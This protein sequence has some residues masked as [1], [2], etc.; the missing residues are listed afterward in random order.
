M[1]ATCSVVTRDEADRRHE[2][3]TRRAAGIAGSPSRLGRFAVQRFNLVRY[4]AFDDMGGR[5]SFSAALLDDTVTD[6]DHL[7][8]RPDRGT[9]VKP[10]SELASEHNLSDEER[11][12]IA[13][14]LPVRAL[15]AVPC[16]RSLG[17]A[18]IDLKLLRD[19]PGAVRASLHARRGGVPQLD[20]V[21]ELDARYLTLLREVEDARAE[22]NRASKA[23]GQASKEASRGDRV[24]PQAGREGQGPL[25]PGSSRS[26]LRSTPQRLICRTSFTARSP[27]ASPRKTTSS[28]E[29]GDRPRFDFEP[30]DH[31]ALGER[32]GIFDGERG[33]R[34]RA[35]G[36]S[37]S[38]GRA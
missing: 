20:E 25:E 19:D 28:R 8:Q 38:W 33:P 4:G 7:H 2:Q 14:P 10:I 1:S 13:G 26:R 35:A 36:S 9:D 29:V 21:M 5:L 32:L 12:A 27:T 15:A 17:P 11:E 24:S 30:Q 23:I 16:Q 37:T 18:V 3:A 6:R 31:V 22:Q 34:P